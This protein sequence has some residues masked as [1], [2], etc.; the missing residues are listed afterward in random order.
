[1]ATA[2]VT[3]SFV[4]GNT[5][6][7]AQHNTNFADLVNFINGS[8]VHVDG[9]KAFTGTVSGVTPTAAAHLTRKDYVDGSDLKRLAAVDAD[10][11]AVYPAQTINLQTVQALFQGGTSVQSTDVNGAVGITFPTPFPN[12]VVVAVLQMGDGAAAANQTFAMYSTSASLFAF[13][14][15]EASTGALITSA[16]PFRFNWIAIGW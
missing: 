6:L 12:G 5:I 13:Y 10:M 16:G 7:A 11:Y 4:T 14:V 15:T 1:M 3:H 8:V 9:S 2:S